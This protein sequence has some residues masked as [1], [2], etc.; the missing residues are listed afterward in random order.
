MSS[1]SSGVAA[2]LVH[3]GFAV[4]LWNYW[5]DNLW[6]MTA[7]KPL[8]GLYIGFGMFVLGFVP[9]MFYV[10]RK[11]VS[12]AIIVAVLLV[13]SVFGSWSAGPVLAP[14][15]NPTPFGLYILFWV[16]IVV[17]VV[18]SGQWEFRRKQRATG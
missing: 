4:I 2:G 5:F 10:R 6:E 11:V 13:L 8:N 17:I 12:P 15:S 3:A 18:I 9:A 14:S 7:T 16:G 1:I